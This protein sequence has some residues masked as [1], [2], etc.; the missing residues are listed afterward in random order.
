MVE[1]HYVGVY[2]KLS[3]IQ[4]FCVDVQSVAHSEVESLL[5]LNHNTRRLI[6][7]IALH[8]SSLL[9]FLAGFP[10]SVI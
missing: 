5:E 6:V 1:H 3:D 8:Q 10:L 2:L 7:R 4:D 9:D